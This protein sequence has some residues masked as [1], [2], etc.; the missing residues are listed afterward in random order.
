MRQVVDVVDRR[1]DKKGP[2]GTHRSLQ[3]P[4]MG[5]NRRRSNARTVAPFLARQLGDGKEGA[6]YRLLAVKVELIGSDETALDFRAQSG[7]VRRVRASGEM[8]HRRS[9]AGDDL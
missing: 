1:R 6:E 8:L 9:L 5:R 3:S 7:P 2:V 4:D